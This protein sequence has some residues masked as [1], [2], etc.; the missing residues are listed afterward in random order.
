M[1]V[2][3]V[4]PNLQFCQQRPIVQVLKFKKA[5]ELRIV[6]AVAYFHKIVGAGLLVKEV[7][8]FKFTALP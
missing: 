5:V 2:V 7:R 1:A 3:A 8:D 4:L 6:N